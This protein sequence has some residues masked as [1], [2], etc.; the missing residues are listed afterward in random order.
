M[1][2]FP[3]DVIKSFTREIVPR[4]IISLLEHGLMEQEAKRKEEKAEREREKRREK[5]RG[6]THR[7][8]PYVAAPPPAFSLYVRTIGFEFGFRV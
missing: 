1:S 5:E 2:G 3:K 4:N 6:W 8:V 7:F